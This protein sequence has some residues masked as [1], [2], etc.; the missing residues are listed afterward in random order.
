MGMRALDVAKET[1]H[2]AVQIGQVKRP[3]RPAPAGKARR[4]QITAAEPIQKVDI[5][6]GDLVEAKV[7]AF[8]DCRIGRGIVLD[9]RLAVNGTA[10]VTAMP[11]FTPARSRV[12]RIDTFTAVPRSAMRRLSENSGSPSQQGNAG[13]YMGDFQTG[14]GPQRRATPEPIHYDLT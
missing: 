8:A 7:V 6:G 9:G 11:W 1:G 12:V 5:V 13:L 14:L 4:S 2:G 3:D 10:V